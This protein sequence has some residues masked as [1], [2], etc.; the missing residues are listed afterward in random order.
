MNDTVKF[1]IQILYMEG[2]NKNSSEVL[3]K[4]Y[5]LKVLASIINNDTIFM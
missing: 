2:T 3:K 5:L 4:K 1:K